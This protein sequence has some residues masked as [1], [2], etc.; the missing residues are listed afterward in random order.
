MSEPEFITRKQGVERARA[1][2]IPLVLSRIDKDTSQGVG[3]KA[4]ARYGVSDLY[5]P[6]EFDRYLDTR[7]VKVSS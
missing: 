7:V 2:G 4:A 6:E 5:T 1:R 3:P